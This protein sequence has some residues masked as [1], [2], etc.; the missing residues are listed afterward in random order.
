[1][2]HLFC[3]LVK[4]ISNQ[5]LPSCDLLS[6]NASFDASNNLVFVCFFLFLM[7]VSPRIG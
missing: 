5:N 2:F 6:V 1:M 7:V 3:E 4:S